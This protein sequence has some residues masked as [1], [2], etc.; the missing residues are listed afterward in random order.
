MMERFQE[1]YA[2]YTASEKKANGYL[3]V[4]FMKEIGIT[5]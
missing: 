3:I 2:S 1:A 4:A 5:P